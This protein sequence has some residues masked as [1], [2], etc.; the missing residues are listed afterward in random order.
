[1]AVPV[2]LSISVQGVEMTLIQEF[3]TVKTLL[4]WYVP[5]KLGPSMGYVYGF[6]ALDF[7]R[8]LGQNMTMLFWVLEYSKVALRLRMWDD[9]RQNKQDAEEVF[10]KNKKRIQL[11]KKI[12]I[13]FYVII[14]AVKDYS[15]LEKSLSQSGQHHRSKKWMMSLNFYS[16]LTIGLTDMA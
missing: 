1:M 12:L 6:I 11:A 16:S 8:S 5:P 14:I 7:V 13:P 4:S 15:L 3:Y 9:E 2:W 10:D